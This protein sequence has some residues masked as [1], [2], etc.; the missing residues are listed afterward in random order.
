METEKLFLL[1]CWCSKEVFAEEY[2][3]FECIF[4]IFIFL[5]DVKGVVDVG[6]VVGLGLDEFIEVET[7]SGEVIGH[8]G[9]GN[10]YEVGK[11]YY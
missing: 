8:D 6:F 9:G 10:N 2:D 5:Y 4:K 1:N 7:I 11:W 3:F